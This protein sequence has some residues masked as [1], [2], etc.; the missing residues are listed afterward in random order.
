MLRSISFL[1]ALG[2]RQEEQPKMTGKLSNACNQ[3]NML[4]ELGKRGRGASP[5]DGFLRGMGM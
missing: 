5:A 1:T 4:W 2:E 3:R